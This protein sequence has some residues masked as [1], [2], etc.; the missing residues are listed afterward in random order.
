MPVRPARP[1]VRPI[2]ASVLLC[3]VFVY[4]ALD[5]NQP[6][7]PRAPLPPALPPPP[8]PPLWPPHATTPVTSSPTGATRPPAPVD[9]R[10]ALRHAEIEAWRAAVK[11]MRARGYSLTGFYHAS[12]VGSHWPEVM[13]EQLRVL[14]GSRYV[15]GDDDVQYTDSFSHTFGD[16]VYASV[17]REAEALHINIAVPDN[18]VAQYD[19][20]AN[21]IST[22][23]NLTS[24]TKA[25]FTY[26]MNRTIPR[27]SFSRSSAAQQQVYLA[28]SDLSEGEVSTMM[29]L[30]GFCQREVAARRNALVFYVHSKSTVGFHQALAPPPPTNQTR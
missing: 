24:E 6:R 21:L 27:Q 8:P 7:P 28:A 4:L 5:W 25:K 2:A 18:D 15:D 19:L 10:F 29:Q 14:E 16:R 17:L 30:Q 3:F 13:A 22:R 1:T 9:A 11:Q 12:T 23:L 20:V 26:G